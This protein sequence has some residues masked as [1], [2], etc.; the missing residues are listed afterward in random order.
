MQKLRPCVII[1]SNVGNISSSNVIVAPIT[2]TEKEIPSMAKIET[3]IN[4]ENKKT[5]LNG[6]VNL[7]NIQTLSKKDIENVN[8]SIL[9][10]LGLF[11]EIKQLN[12]KIKK[13]EM[14]IDKFKNI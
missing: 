4:L 1:Q 12:D 3:Q 13:Q 5:I 11:K 10:S 7:S 9:I 2:H 8:K 6:Y 14:Y